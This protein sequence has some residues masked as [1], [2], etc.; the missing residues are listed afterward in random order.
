MREIILIFNL[1]TLLKRGELLLLP[2]LL[3]WLLSCNQQK[4]NI[5]LE[6]TKT[7]PFGQTSFPA[8]SNNNLIVN[9]NDSLYLYKLSH[10]KVQ[11]I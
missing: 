9:A 10:L 1:D 5:S 7:I 8:I 6:K 4:N 3:F 2:F 11:I